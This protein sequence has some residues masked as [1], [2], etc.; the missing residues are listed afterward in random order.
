MGRRW[1]GVQSW[2]KVGGALE[3]KWGWAGVPGPCG[4]GAELWGLGGRWAGV[5]GPGGRW[6]G[7]CGLGRRWAGVRERGGLG[8]GVRWVGRPGSRAPG[9]RWTGLWGLG[10]GWT[11]IHVGEGGTPGPGL[12]VGRGLRSGL[13]LGG[14]LGCG[15]FTPPAPPYGALSPRKGPATLRHLCGTGFRARAG[16]RHV[17][18]VPN[19]DARSLWLDANQ[20]RTGCGLVVAGAAGVGCGH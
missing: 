17:R 10:R 15:R 16:R 19:P 9:G 20:P 8:S 12:E 2:V 5:R 7:F 3:S 4:R 13:E 11:G 6:A 1:A 14:R 18:Y